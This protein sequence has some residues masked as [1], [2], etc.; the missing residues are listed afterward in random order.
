MSA[1]N[2]T[3]ASPT[4][5]LPRARREEVIPASQQSVAPASESP[6]TGSRILLVDDDPLVSMNTTYMLM[7]LGHSVLESPSA[8]HA[9]SILEADAKFDLVIT[10]YAMPGMSGLDLAMKIKQLKPQMPVIIATGYAEL[11]PHATLGFLRLSKP[12]TQL[13]L[14]SALAKASAQGSRPS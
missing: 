13:Q 11:P 12:F 6:G 5:W 1:S 8:A 7:D 3:A 14:A 10:D 9:L 2:R 4:A